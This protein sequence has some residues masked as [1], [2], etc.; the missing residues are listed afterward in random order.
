MK[1]SKVR[2]LFGVVV[3]IMILMLLTT[4]GANAAALS[5]GQWKVIA[6][7]NVPPASDL[8][9]LGEIAANDIWA[10]GSYGSSDFFTQY[11]LTEHWDGMTWN[12]I[13]SPNV[14]KALDDKLYAVEGVATNDVWAVGESDNANS[15][16]YKILTE[17]WNGTQWS[18]IPSV[19][20]NRVVYGLAA[21]A[22][23]N[24]WAVGASVNQQSGKSQTLVIHWNGTAWSTVASP[25]VGSFSNILQ[26]VRAVSANDIWAVGYSSNANTFTPTKTLTEHWNGTSWSVIASP[27]VGK[28]SNVLS[29]LTPIASNDVWADGYSC[30]TYDCANSGKVQTMTLHWN[31]T[32]WNVIPSAD[33]GS[34]SST[35][36]GMAA[37]SSNNVW[38]VGYSCSTKTCFQFN[39]GKAQTLVEQWNGTAWSVVPSPNFDVGDNVLIDVVSIPGSSQAWATG[40]YNDANPLSHPLTE[41]Y[42]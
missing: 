39:S 14:P 30:A 7:W 11:T 33:V 36:L 8:T 38:A 5:S 20:G 15:N 24:V 40:Y 3:T 41:C 34:G 19:T 35:L 27:N 13:P 9:A 4:E 25:S 17:H 12:L 29:G 42:C 21:I 22:S 6:S 31:G 28:S 32:S 26:S 23:N 16:N 1:H 10:V 18:I 37:V 2:I